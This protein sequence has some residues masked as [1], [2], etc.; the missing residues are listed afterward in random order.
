VSVVV[1]DVDAAVSVVGVAVTVVVDVVVDR[2]ELY[3]NNPTLQYH[4]SSFS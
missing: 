3:N 4:I 1:V 2:N